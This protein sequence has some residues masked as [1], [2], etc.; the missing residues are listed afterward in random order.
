MAGQH[1]RLTLRSV[2]AR[3][4]GF[5]G[6]SDDPWHRHTAHAIRSQL[7][8]WKSDLFQTGRD[9]ILNAGSGGDDLGIGSP[10]TIH[11]DI[12]ERRLLSRDGLR[13]VGSVEAIPLSSG[14]V[15][16][17]ICVGSVINYCDA[18]ATIIEFG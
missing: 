7:R 12:A 4:N 8:Q 2:R 11:L 17:T 6:E 10:R 14:S 13:L 3:Y 1:P 16:S 9:R 18:A 15:D 5:D